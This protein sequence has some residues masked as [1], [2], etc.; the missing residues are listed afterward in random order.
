MLGEIYADLHEVGKTV[1]INVFMMMQE[2]LETYI[3]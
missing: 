1:S 2:I 3:T